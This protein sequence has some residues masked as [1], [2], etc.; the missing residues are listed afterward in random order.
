M[1]LHG[2][3]PRLFK[4]EHWGKFSFSA[5]ALF[6]VLCCF[7]QTFLIVP[8]G[9]LAGLLFLFFVLFVVVV[10]FVGLVLFFCLFVFILKTCSSKI[11][12]SL[13]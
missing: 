3:L 7:T 1:S 13:S 9:S 6:Q 12:F 5:M 11:I 2:N 8:P 4:T 10:F